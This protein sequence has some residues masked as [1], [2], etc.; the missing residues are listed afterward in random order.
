MKTSAKPAEIVTAH[1]TLRPLRAA[2]AAAGVEMLTDPT[3][4]A[5]YVLPDF[6]DPEEAAQLYLRLSHLAA[7]PEHF[8]YGLYRGERLVGFINDVRVEE[9]AIELGYVVAREQRC[10]GYAT[11]ALA[12]CIRAL[13][14]LGFDTVGAG[15]FEGNDA[16]RRVMEKCGMRPACKSEILEYR[17][18]ERRCVYYEITREDAAFA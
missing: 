12:A 11:E 18:E 14:A 13:F 2:D 10:R 17:G 8:I 9:R 7:Q 16:S 6:A 1:L 4:A 5:T 15:F 3:V